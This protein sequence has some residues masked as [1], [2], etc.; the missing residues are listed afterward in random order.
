MGMLK[1]SNEN[2]SLQRKPNPVI[3]NQIDRNDLNINKMLS[4]R[5]SDPSKL[6]IKSETERATIKVD[7]HIRNILT[8]LVNIGKFD[9]QKHAVES[10]CAKEVE[11]MNEEELKRF[12]FILDTLE[13]KD[14]NKQQRKKFCFL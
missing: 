12:E 3:N 7:N 4:N 10:M 9:S 8:A 2:N 6:G 5:Q 14:Y 1:K 11:N 13:L